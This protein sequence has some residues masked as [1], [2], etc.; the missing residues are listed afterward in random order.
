MLTDN[1]FRWKVIDLDRRESK[2]DDS[3]W[4]PFAA[5]VQNSPLKYLDGI[6]LDDC[7]KLRNDGLLHRMRYFLRRV[8]SRSRQDDEFS[9]AAAEQFAAE[10]SEEVSAAE[11]E[12]KRIDANLLKWFARETAATVAAVP[13]VGLANAGWLAASLGILGAANIIDAET[14]RRNLPHRMPGAFFLEPKR[15]VEQDK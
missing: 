5:A 3:A 8:W 1:R 2:V 6:S 12:W 11:D 15:R 9:K 13:K 14:K 4:E 10:L 7:L